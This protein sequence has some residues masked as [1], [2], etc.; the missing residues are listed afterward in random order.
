MNCLIMKRKKAG[1]GE[2]DLLQ[3]SKKPQELSNLSGAPK[4]IPLSLCIFP[5]IF[6][7]VCWKS[8]DS[9]SLFWNAQPH[10]GNQGHRSISSS[11]TLHPRGGNG[12]ALSQTIFGDFP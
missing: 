8:G 9:P 12:N 10:P 2:Y 1:G 7:A 6:E 5:E 4:S 11:E 3:S